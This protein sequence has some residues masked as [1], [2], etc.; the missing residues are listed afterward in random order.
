MRI[1][2]MNN[3]N[4]HSKILLL[5]DDEK[6][7]SKKVDVLNGYGFNVEGETCV[8]T[9]LDKIKSNEYDLLLLDYLMD[10]MR[11]DKVVEEIRSFNADLYILLLTGYAEAPALEILTGL[12]VTAYCEKSNDNNQLLILIESALKSV[13]M[14]KTV[15]MTRDSLN[16]ILLAV[17]KIYQFK[18]I[19][20]ILQEILSELLSIVH[21]EDAFILVDN[22]SDIEHDIHEGTFF[23]GIGEY[24]DGFEKINNEL[25]EHI[26][27]VRSTK[28]V[29]IL[30][31]SIILPLISEIY[32]TL[33]VIYISF[34]SIKI[35]SEFIDVFRIYSTIAAS[36]IFNAL[37][38]R[39]LNVRDEKLQQTREELAI[40]YLST[41]K[42][43]RL[44]IDAKDQYTCGHSDRVSKYAV[45]IGQAFNL[46]QKELDLLRDGGIFHDV[47][48]IGIDDSILKKSGRIETEEYREIKKHP[49]R[50]ALILS[51]VS[52][53]K[54]IVPIVLYHHER[55]DGM[56]YPK[57]LIGEEIP[58]LSRILCVADALDAMT[59]DRIYK[60]KI[61]ITATMEE[62]K[63]SSGTQFDPD[64]VRI[65]I[66]LINNH[67]IKIL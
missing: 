36:S 24:S 57:G 37:L 50:G 25:F 33:G 2:K 6:Y 21:V 45:T 8:K 32:D 52:M 42:T 55:Y 28:E 38:H 3:T 13:K 64:V 66:E 62:L 27:Y 9:A 65:T 48:K 1:S 7:V 30:E 5:D 19:D 20:C 10:E 46:S 49:E 11:G 44:A 26:G 54:D 15:K 59:T 56:G 41:V 51:A 58:F 31:N 12:D 47:G 14:M 40:W 4:M 53:F 67:T 43:I 35:Y 34:K 61:D 16:K 39:M 17:P 60:S 23:S 29:S 18:P 63:L 22:I